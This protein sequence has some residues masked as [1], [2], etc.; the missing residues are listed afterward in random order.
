MGRSRRKLI[1]TISSVGFVVLLAAVLASCGG[2]GDYNVG[3]QAVSAAI[4]EWGQCLSSAG[5]NLAVALDN[6]TGTSGSDG[7]ILLT[8]GNGDKFLVTH[9]SL[10]E[11]VSPA[12]LTARRHVH[13][14]LSRNQNCRHG[15]L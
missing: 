13:T 7:G 5:V 6:V 11:Q 10:D 8:L 4:N 3:V 2:S 9:R 12:N 15:A 14:G 1:N